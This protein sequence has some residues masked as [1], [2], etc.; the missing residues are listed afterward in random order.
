MPLTTD[1][2]IRQLLEQTK[3]IAVVGYSSDPTRPS[4][5]VAQALKAA[6][7]RVY[8]VNP[9]LKPTAEEPVWARLS[10][11]PEPIDVVDI[12][13]RAEDVPEVVETAITAGAKAIWMQLGIVNEQAAKRAEQAGLKV[14]MDHCMKVEHRRLV[15]KP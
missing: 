14:V 9:T 7:Y 1:E 2:Q 8:P 4:H 13:R 12:F 3:T 15:R 11:I 10:E 6:G 5:E